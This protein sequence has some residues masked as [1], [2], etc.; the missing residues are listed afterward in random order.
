MPMLGQFFQ[1]A[2][3]ASWGGVLG[4]SIWKETPG[5]AGEIMYH[6]WPGN[7]LEPPPPPISSS[8]GAGGS[9]W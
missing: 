2:S 6:G 9:G 7:A 1:D 3:Q 8:G 4:M 5:Y